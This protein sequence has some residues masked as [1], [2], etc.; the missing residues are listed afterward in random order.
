[1]RY[2]DEHKDTVRARIVETASR[3]LRRSGLDGV[4]IPALM[5][6]VGLTHGGF[7]SHFGDRDELVAEAVRHA[8]LETAEGVFESAPT[9][10]AALAAYLSEQHADHPDHGCVVAALGADAP[11][12]RAPVRK[13]FGWAAVGLLQLVQDK[14]DSRQ[15]TPSDEALELT[16]R[17][18][19]AIVLARLLDDPR[20]TARLLAVARRR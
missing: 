11:R 15:K 19:G 5:K 14:L 6:K 16:S 20:L 9:L 8:A 10:D 13:A 18:V 12:Q 1:M 7:Y 2:P 17:M 4:S 3:A